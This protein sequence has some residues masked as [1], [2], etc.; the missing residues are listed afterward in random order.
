MR[1]GH[2]RPIVSRDSYHDLRDRRHFDPISHV[3]PENVDVGARAGTILSLGRSRYWSSWTRIKLS[4]MDR[5]AVRRRKE[6]TRESV[7]ALL[8]REKV[9][10]FPGVRG[11][12][13][14][15]VGA[16]MAAAK[17][18][19]LAAWREARCIKSNPDSPQAPARKRALQ[20][21]K[22]VYMA[23]P[24]LREKACF[25]ELDPEKVGDLRKASNIKGAFEVGRPVEIERV[26]KIDLVLC[27][28]VAVTRD[29]RR[30]G[31]GC[32]F[33]DLEYGLLTEAGKL[34]ANT[35]VVTTVHPLQIVREIPTLEH[36]FPLDAIM[37]PEKILFCEHEWPRPS[38]IYRD[39]ID[40]EKAAEIPCL[41]SE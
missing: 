28:S 24:R 11:R 12:I 19:E 5:E 1:E 9:G 40:P 37:T 34:T 31:K 16:E 29:G 32:G 17:L 26:K 4:E 18:E 36:D 10:R 15:F 35:P 22:T 14:N 13:P 38:G 27:G 39:L 2:F 21:G 3:V 30:L 7:W 23:V 25:I 6:E 8:E 41:R 33:S 20:A